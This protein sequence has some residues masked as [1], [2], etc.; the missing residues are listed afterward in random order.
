MPFLINVCCGVLPLRSQGVR[1]ARK[2][3]A[4]SFLFFAFLTSRNFETFAYIAV[5]LIAFVLLNKRRLI[6]CVSSILKP[7]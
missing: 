5:K 7:I 2:L 3:F 6:F 4:A 1:K